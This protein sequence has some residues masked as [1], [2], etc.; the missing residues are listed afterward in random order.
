[1]KLQDISLS[2][3]FRNISDQFEWIFTGVY[4]PNADRDRR[5]L[6]EEMTGLISWWDAPWYIGGDFNVVRFPS[7]KSRQATFSTSMQNFS[8]FISD[9][10]LLETPLKGGKY[11]WSNNR[12]FTF[13]SRIDRFLFSPDRADHF[14]LV[15]QQ[16]LPRV[17]SDHF[18][19]ILN[20]GRIIGGKRNFLFENMWLKAE[21]FVDRVQSWWEAYI[22]EGSPSYIM[23]SKLKALKVDLKQWNAQEFGNVAYQQQCNLHSLHVL[24]TL[25][26]SWS[27]SEEEK[28]EKAKLILDWE[29]NNLVGDKNLL[30]EISW[31][32]KSRATW[33]KEGDKNSKFFHSVANS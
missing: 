28:E 26:E 2:C 1:M 24:E 31:K 12:E 17:L 21:G 27:L 8:N 4:G 18:T 15:T 19:I 32:Q 3:K 6:W 13:V 14:G 7:E 10:G 9:F 30:E 25:A 5:A 29:K 22:F 20:C 11:T 16:R 33:L 23:A